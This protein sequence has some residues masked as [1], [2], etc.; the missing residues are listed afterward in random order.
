M[1]QKGEKGYT[2]YQQKIIRN[3]YEKQRPSP[4]TEVGRVSIKF[5]CGNE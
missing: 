2:P 3:F 1:D 4:N 5:I